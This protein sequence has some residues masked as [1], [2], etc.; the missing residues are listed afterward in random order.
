MTYH[1][2]PPAGRGRQLS[3]DQESAVAK[4]VAGGKISEAEIGLLYAAAM[5]ADAQNA[6]RAQDALE[7]THK[8]GR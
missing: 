5:Y 6:A 2:R 3:P 1:H 7:A 4:A 8:R